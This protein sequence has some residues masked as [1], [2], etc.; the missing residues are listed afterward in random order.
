MRTAVIRRHRKESSPV[1]LSKLSLTHGA[2][3]IVVIATFAIAQTSVAQ[4]AEAQLS[5]GGWSEVQVPAP[6]DPRVDVVDGQLIATRLHE[7]DGPHHHEMHA[8]EHDRRPAKMHP[9]AAAW[10]AHHKHWR[11]HLQ[12]KTPWDDRYCLPNHQRAGK[13]Q[14]VSPFAKSSPTRDYEVG[15]VGGGSAFAGDRR[16]RSEGTFGMDYSGVLFE[17]RVWLKWNHGRK[18]QGGAGAYETDGPRLHE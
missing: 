13:P 16:C 18:P 10:E 8:E 6:V 2:Q 7:L 12:P 1:S 17:R 15:Y 11:E 5:D 3:A 9:H 4:H 14:C